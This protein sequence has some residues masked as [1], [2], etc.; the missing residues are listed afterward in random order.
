[1]NSVVNLSGNILQQENFYLLKQQRLSY[2][3][4]CSMDGF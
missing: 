4:H 2:I 1:M 3:V